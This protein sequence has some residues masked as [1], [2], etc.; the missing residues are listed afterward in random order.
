[1]AKIVEEKIETKV[2]YNLTKRLYQY[3]KPYKASL[4]IGIILVLA[5]SA[6]ELLKPML[7]GSAIDD[8]IEKYDKIYGICDNSDLY[9]K[10]HYLTVTNIED[11]DRFAS[12]I[13]LMI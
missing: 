13:S 11:C 7:I 12:I 3:I 4:I 5:I 8:Y 1:M 9:F 10:G 6:M 2:S